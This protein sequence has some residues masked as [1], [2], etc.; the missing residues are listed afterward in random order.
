MEEELETPRRRGTEGKKIHI[1]RKRLIIFCLAS[2][3]TISN[4]I[5][6]IEKMTAIYA[7][8]IGNIIFW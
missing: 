7:G 2:I 1:S 6:K 4:I 3:G 8:V 5:S